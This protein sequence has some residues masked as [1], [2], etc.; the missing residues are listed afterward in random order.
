MTHI[1]HGLAEEFPEYK[2]CLHDLKL[3]DVRFCQ[4]AESYNYLNKSIQRAEAGLDPL[5][6][7]KL[8]EMLKER[9]HLKDEIFRKLKIRRTETSD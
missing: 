8:S 5:D 1:A 7:G 2:D 4:L 6:E 9:V 3:S